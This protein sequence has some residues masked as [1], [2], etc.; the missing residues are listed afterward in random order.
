MK[1]EVPRSRWQAVQGFK[2]IQSVLP[3][4]LRRVM[5]QLELSEVGEMLRRCWQLQATV[6]MYPLHGGLHI[7]PCC[8]RRYQP[9]ATH[10]LRVVRP[11]R[12]AGTRAPAG[13]PHPWRTTKPGSAAHPLDGAEANVWRQVGAALVII[14]PRCKLL[15]G[16]PLLHP[17][18]VQ[19]T[20]I[21]MDAPC[22]W[23]SMNQRERPYFVTTT[24]CETHTACRLPTKR[25]QSS[26]LIPDP[27]STKE[28]PCG[29]S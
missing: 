11:P 23:L 6:R 4:G 12:M 19:R 10:M 28:G 8:L 25:I 15:D 20:L 1:A 13:P 29:V 16:P 7:G 9:D 3:T 18:H 24:S 2:R 17:M 14:H 21:K 26:P 27:L 22:A 5:L